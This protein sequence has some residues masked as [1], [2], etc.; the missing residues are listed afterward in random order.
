MYYWGDTG[1]NKLLHQKTYLVKRMILILNQIHLRILQPTGRNIFFSKS[2][3]KF[4]LLNMQGVHHLVKGR[5]IPLTA[6]F[7][8][9]ILDYFMNLIQ[10]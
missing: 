5:N 4:N 2:L 10:K 3:F 6:F 8:F 1:S 7:F 9:S